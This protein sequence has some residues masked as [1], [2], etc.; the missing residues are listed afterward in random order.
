[1]TTIIRS[2]AEDV[3]ALPSSLMT[4]V[5]LQE[6]DEVKPVIK[7]HTLRL[8]PLDRFLALRGVLDEDRVFDKAWKTGE[9]AY[10]RI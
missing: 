8:T 6:G 7:G 5:T 2:S 1:M 3:I 10:L 4:I 9:S